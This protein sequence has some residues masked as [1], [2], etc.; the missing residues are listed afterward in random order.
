ML[1]RPNGR[2]A[3]QAHSGNHRRNSLSAASE[4][5]DED[6]SETRP[7]PRTEPRGVGGSVGKRN[8]L[9]FTLGTGDVLKIDSPEF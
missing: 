3:A 4:D 9:R 1:P 6:L 7:T 8:N 2:G 5:D